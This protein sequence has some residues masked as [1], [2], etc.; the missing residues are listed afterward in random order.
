MEARVARLRRSKPLRRSGLPAFSKVFEV[1]S[2]YHLVG[3]VQEGSHTRT[4]VAELD[5][6]V[7]LIPAIQDF[8]LDRGPCTDPEASL[9]VPGE[10]M[11]RVT[12]NGPG[13]A[14]SEQLT[15]GHGTR[16]IPAGADCHENAT[17]RK[18]SDVGP[19]A[20]TARW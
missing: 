17:P 10:S 13:S 9:A 12:P 5:L 16:A 7:S 15:W 4:S 19:D 2:L 20:A 11:S 6:N 18:T 14:K 3:P 8:V 1:K